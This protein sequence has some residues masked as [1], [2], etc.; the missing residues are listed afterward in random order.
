MINRSLILSV[1][2]FLIT[3]NFS[4]IR[5]ALIREK[6]FLLLRFRLPFVLHFFNLWTVRR[7]FSKKKE[8]NL[9]F[10]IKRFLDMSKTLFFI[11]IIII[12]CDVKQVR[13][14]TRRNDAH[15]YWQCTYQFVKQRR[16]FVG[17]WSR[18]QRTPD[19]LWKSSFLVSSL[20]DRDLLLS[21][22]TTSMT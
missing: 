14:K 22:K 9:N 17:K 12:G 18:T 13:G 4:S 1:F 8:K 6:E 5:P 19:F 11:I 21:N 16:N 2:L 3:M 7:K 20:A 15:G 10:E